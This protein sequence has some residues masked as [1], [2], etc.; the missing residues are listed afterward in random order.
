MHIWLIKKVSVCW[1][2]TKG[3]LKTMELRHTWPNIQI[4]FEFFECHERGNMVFWQTLSAWKHGSA[5]KCVHRNASPAGKYWFGLCDLTLTKCIDSFMSWVCYLMSFYWTFIQQLSTWL[6]KGKDQLLFYFTSNWSSDT[7]T[8]M[9]SSILSHVFFW[10]PNQS[11][12]NNGNESDPQHIQYKTITISCIKDKFI[13]MYAHML[14]F[15]T[16]CTVCM[17][18][19][20]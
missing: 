16:Y 6:F 11:W 5:W 14:T 9:P 1:K 13:H 2:E 19:L 3:M 15:D 20:F 8:L 17:C 18:A 7:C 4:P 12:K 10:K